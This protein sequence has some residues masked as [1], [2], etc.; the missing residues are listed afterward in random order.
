MDPTTLVDVEE[1]LL[2][3][4]VY[5][6]ED[7]YETELEK[8]F[9]RSWLFLA[10]E[11]QLP[12]PGDFMTAYMGADPV[13]LVRQRDGSL[14]C[15]LNACR[16]R[17]MRVTCE[18]FGTARGFTCPYHGWSYSTAGALTAMPEEYVYDGALDKAKWGLRPVAQLDSYRG[19]VFATF[20]PAAP[21][22]DE[23][24]GDMKFYLDACFDRVEGGVELLGGTQKWR[25]Q[26]NWKLAADQF[27][28]DN[29]HL[30]T[31][32][33]SPYSVLNV[34]DGYEHTAAHLQGGQFSS[35]YGHGTGWFLAQTAGLDDGI[36]PTS[37]K[38]YFEQTSAETSARIGDVRRRM[39]SHATVFPNFS[40]LSA[41][42]P[43]IRVWHPKGP[44]EMEVWSW[45][46]VDASAPPEVKEDLRRMAAVTFG[47]SGIFE[48]DDASIWST[49]QR[50]LQSPQLRKQPLNIQMGLNR[51]V[52][53]DPELPG[54]LAAPISEMS[55]RGFYERWLAL[56]THDDDSWPHPNGQ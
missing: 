52:Q 34:S 46:Y 26:A 51:A 36:L 31:T 13:V 21:S 20:D 15:F 37:V 38:T 10:H 16:H 18:D 55:L 43:T 8:I 6:D 14:S 12:R 56:M 23:Y 11:C 5:S 35:P 25:I 2:Y 39:E 28:S 4:A 1:G 7:I 22:L 44:A 17:G 45:A 3:P 49:L 29:Y 27:S 47:P 54:R 32:H 24:L 9:G 48:Q 40:Y 19:L 30:F 41:D 42:V 53:S 33:I 50:N